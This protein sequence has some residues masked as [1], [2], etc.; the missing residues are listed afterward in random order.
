[1][2]G[3]VNICEDWNKS[4]LTVHAFSHLSKQQL[5]QV[6]NSYVRINNHP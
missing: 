5:S 4:K 2:K 3:L 1:M 6:T